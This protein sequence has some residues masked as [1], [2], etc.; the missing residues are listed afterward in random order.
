MTASNI[1]DRHQVP[2]TS[3][4]AKA[5]E[6]PA[7][8]PES[9]GATKFSWPGKDAKAQQAARDAHFLED[10]VKADGTGGSVPEKEA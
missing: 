9:K 8:K 6:Q 2:Q 7:D 4:T 1:H 3:D 5:D 10:G